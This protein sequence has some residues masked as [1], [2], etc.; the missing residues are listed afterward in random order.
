VE[1]VELLAVCMSCRLGVVHLFQHTVTP[2]C[3]GSM[4]PHVGPA[5]ARVVRG[6]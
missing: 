3:A 4:E 2:L 1:L 5:Y 6:S